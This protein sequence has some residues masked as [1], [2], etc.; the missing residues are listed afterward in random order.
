[1][2]PILLTV[3]LLAG[4]GFPP[5]RVLRYHDRDIIIANPEIVD[6]FCS[7]TEG[8]W[9]DGTPRAKGAPVGGCYQKNPTIWLKEPPNAGTDLHENRHHD[10][11]KYSKNPDCGR[12]P[13]KEGYR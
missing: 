6:A 5:L 10:C 4:C 13:T 9:D 8:K 11:A 12:D 7:A 1:M 2:R 3:L